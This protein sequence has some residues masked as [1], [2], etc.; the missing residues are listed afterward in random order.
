MPK[1][2]DEGWLPGKQGQ[3]ICNRR[4]FAPITYIDA[5]SIAKAIDKSRGDVLRE[6]RALVDESSR[7]SADFRLVPATYINE[8]SHK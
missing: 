4:N 5:S 3:A 6:F 1:V 7:L 2:E 8:Q